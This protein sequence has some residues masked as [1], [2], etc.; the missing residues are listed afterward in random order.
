MAQV[1]VFP[2]PGEKKRA[3]QCSTGYP[4]TATCSSKAK[5][6]SQFVFQ[7]KQSRGMRDFLALEEGQEGKL[8]KEKKLNSTTRCL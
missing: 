7:Q 5:A 1:S 6:G 4:E 3:V 2:Q 8:Y